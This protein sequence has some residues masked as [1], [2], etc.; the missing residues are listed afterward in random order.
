MVVTMA[1]S[2]QAAWANL[3]PDP[4]S[5]STSTTPPLKASFLKGQSAPASTGS[6]AGESPSDPAPSTP[7]GPAA[8]GTP[9]TDLPLTAADLTAATVADARTL[10]DGEGRRV[11][12]NDLMDATSTT[13][14]NPDGSLTTHSF[15]APVRVRQG[16]RW[17]PVD[18]TILPWKGR[19]QPAATTGDVTFSAGGDTALVRQSLLAGGVYGFD[20]PSA[21]PAPQTQ[22]STVTY[23]NVIDHGDLVLRALP[24][25]YEISLVLRARPAGPLELSLPVVL[26][27]GDRLVAAAGGSRVL[28]ASGTV[29]AVVGQTLMTGA[30]LE[31]GSE[32]PTASSVV[33]TSLTGDAD[34]GQTLVLRPDPAFV[35]DP[36]V[37][38]PITIDPT[39]NLADSKDTYVSNAYTG[40]SYYTST[41]LHVGYYNTPAPAAVGRS[42]V[43]FNMGAVHGNKVLTANLELYDQ[44]QWACNQPM[45]VQSGLDFNS[46]TTWANQPG[47]D[48]AT[49][50]ATPT[51]NAGDTCGGAKYVAI[52]IP[53]LAQ[54]WADA[55]STTGIARLT[56]P[57]EAYNYQY[58][59]FSSANAGSAQAPYVATT[60]ATPPASPS[61]VT[62]TAGNAQATVTWV[63][64][65]NNGGSAIT[66][67]Y[68]NL[69]NS[70]G[71][72]L[73]QHTVTTTSYTATGLTNGSSYYFKIYAINA[74][75]YGGGT[76]SNTVTPAGPPGAPSPVT[77]GAN[78]TATS[79]TWGA[80]PAN[81]SA[82]TGYTVTRFLA[83]TNTLLATTS[84]P[85]A[86]RSQ[87]DTCAVG[88]TYYYRIYASNAKGNSS[89]VQSSTVT[90]GPNGDPQN[91]RAGGGDKT[92]QVFWTNPS[93]DGP[94]LGPAVTS[95]T[96]KLYLHNG[97]TSTQ[98]GTAATVS[99][100]TR[101]GT[102][103]S[104]NGYTI[105]NGSIYY[106]TVTAVSA[107]GSSN[108]VPSNDVTAG[109]PLP[110][111]SV[112]ATAADRSASVTWAPPT[113]NCPQGPCA[114]TYNVSL[115]NQD[116]STTVRTDAV[117][118][119]Q[120]TDTFT[121][122]TNGTRYY[123]SISNTTDYN[124]TSPAASS[125]TV[126]PGLPTAPTSL[127]ATGGANTASV[128]WAA[129]GNDGPPNGPPV[130]AYDI[131]LYDSAGNLL[132][133]S[134][135]Q[136]SAARSYAFS[137]PPSNGL[138]VYFTVHAE[139]ANG[140]GPDGTSNTVHV[141]DAPD[142]PPGPITA[143]E[144]A[145]P[146]YGS[147]SATV[148]W[149]LPDDNGSAIDQFLIQAVDP[150]T[151]NP[152]GQ[153]KTVSCG[154][155]CA[156]PVS[157]TVTGLVYGSSYAFRVA[158]HNS[159]NP[160]HNADLAGTGWSSW[161]PTSGTV[162]IGRPSTLT[163]TLSAI[164]SNPDQS[165]YERGQ[166]AIFTIAV[167][168]PN[169]SKV[170]TAN[171][172]DPFNGTFDVGSTSPVIETTSTLS[173]GTT[174]GCAGCTVTAGS[175]LI[176]GQSLQPGET[177]TF[178]VAGV[179]TGIPS[180]GASDSARL[181]QTLLNI[182]SVADDY[183]GNY[184][185]QTGTVTPAAITASAPQATICNA[186][187]GDEP[188]WTYAS[189]TVGVASSAAVNVANGN[190][191][192]Q[193]TDSTPIQAHGRL[194][195]VLRRTYNS[196]DNVLETLP[197][198][199]GK[200]WLLDLGQTDD[201]AGDGVTATAL[202]VPTTQSLVNTVANPLAVTL[203]DRDGTRHVF[204]PKLLSAAA[205]ATGL[206]PATSTLGA[207][208]L[209]LPA[210]I[211]GQ[212]PYTNLCVD[213][214]Y[215][216]P[217]GVHLAMWRYIAIRSTSP[218]SSPC[219]AANRDNSTT[220]IAVGYVTE[221]P[222]R[223]RAEFKVPLNATT[224]APS[225]P[226]GQLTDLTDASGNTLHYTWNTLAQLTRVDESTCTAAPC[227]SM[228]VKYYD[229]GGADVTGGAGSLTAIASSKV[230]D[231]AGRVTTYTFAS[232]SGTLSGTSFASA[233][234]H[235]ARLLTKVTNPD[236]T[237]VA[238]AYQGAGA[239]CGAADGQLCQITDER[240]KTT[241]FGYDKAA[242]SHP[243]LAPPRVTSITDRR[244]YATTLGYS[245]A[246]STNG[247]QVTVTESAQNH[248]SDRASSDRQQ[249]YGPID[250]QG[251]V[252]QV[253]EGAAGVTTGTAARIT[254]WTW[255]GTDLPGRTATHCRSSSASVRDNNLCSLTRL[256]SG[257]ATDAPDAV[258]T[259][260][261]DDAGML[262]RQAINTSPTNQLIT[263]YGYTRQYALSDGTITTSAESVG[264]GGT[265][266]APTTPSNVVYTLADRV[267]LV[268]PRGNATGASH[269]SYQVSYVVDNVT[270]AS[271]NTS[272]SAGPCQQGGAPGTPVGN[273]GLT[274]SVTQPYASGNAVAYD[275]YDTYGQTAVT[276]NA[277]G[278]RTTYRY[279]SDGS[280]DLSG[281]APAGG[282]LKSVTDAQG[283]FVVNGY[284]AA[285]HRVRSWDRDAT[286]GTTLSSYPGTVSSP[287]VSGFTEQLFG[288]S[289]NTNA[290]SA[291]SSPWRWPTKTTDALGYTSTTQTDARG[292]ITRA[293]DA[294]GNAA[295]TT[296]DE[297]GN[298]TTS[299]TAANAALG[300]PAPTQ[301]SY[302]AFGDQITLTDP[303]QAQRNSTAGAAV[304]K[305]VTARLYYDTVGRLVETDRV[306]M[307]NPTGTTPPACAT[308]GN[309]DPELPGGAL[310]CKT[311]ASYDSEDNQT[312]GTDPDG[313]VSTFR[314]DANARRTDMFTPSTG[315]GA[316]AS[317]TRVV[318]DE[319]GNTV[320]I[321]NPRQFTDGD[322]TCTGISNP[323]VTKATFDAA[324]RARSSTSYR[325]VGSP[326][327]TQF[328]TDADGNQ[329]QVTDANSHTTSVTFDNL[330][331]VS[332]VTAPGHA[333]A[334]SPGT[335][336]TYHLHSAS[337]DPVATIT[338]GTPTDNTNTST[339]VDAQSFDA[340]HRRIDS[341]HALQVS[342]N[343]SYSLDDPR[344]L[345]AVTSA[346]ATS[347]ATG[348]TNT[349]SRTSY[350]P[351]GNVV[352]AYSP[353]AFTGS[354]PSAT[355][356]TYSQVPGAFSSD[357]MT[358][359]D[360]DADNRPVTAYTPRTSGSVTDPNGNSLTGP[361]AQQC[362]STGPSTANLPSYPGTRVCVRTVNYDADS[363]RSS[364]TL[365][366]A[367]SG[368]PNRR[369]DYTYTT[370]NLVAAVST[371]DPSAGAATGARVTSAAIGYDGSGRPLTGTDVLG[372]VSRTV[373]NP[374]GSVAESDQPTGS[375]GL[376]HAMKYVYNAAGQ[377]T[378]ATLL[379]T[380]SGTAVTAGSAT[381][382]DTTTTVYYA[383]GLT[384]QVS[385][386]AVGAS[387]SDVTQYSYDPVGN[388]SATS[389]PSANAATR[390]ANNTNGTTTTYTYYPD[391][392]IAT[393]LAP[394]SADGTKLRRTSYNYDDAGRKTNVGV[395]L[396][397]PAPTNSVVTAGSAQS[398]TYQP[399]GWM[400]QQTGRTD[401]TAASNASVYD[402]DGN[403]T[404]F[405][406]TFNPASPD[407]SA[408]PGATSGIVG[409]Q[410]P[411]DSA[412]Y[413]L[414]GG[415]RS[416]SQNPG[417]GVVRSS[418]FSI[419]A[420]GSLT[421]RIDRTAAGDKTT[422]YAYGDAGQP[423]M[424]TSGLEDGAVT[425]W[426][427]DK[428]GN[429][430]RQNSGN[431]TVTTWQ[432]DN[433]SSSGDNS[434]TRIGL[435]S[436][437]N[438]ANA[439]TFD[440][441]DI[442]YSYDEVGRVLTEQHSGKGA[443]GAALAN[444]T[445]SYRYQQD[446]RLSSF[447]NG[448]AAA[449]NVT[450]DHDGNR[451]TYG[452]ATYTYNAD[453]S[454]ATSRANATLTTATHNYSY[455][456]YGR[457]TGDSCTTNS[458]DGL[459]RLT[460]TAYGTSL[461]ATCSQGVATTTSS[462][463]YR[464]DPMDRQTERTSTAKNALGKVTAT[465]TDNN[466]Y[467]GGGQTVVGELAGNGVGGT[468]VNR[469]YQLDASGTVSAL[470]STALE[471][472]TLDGQ[473]SVVA[474]TSSSGG[475]SSVLCALR[476]DPYGQNVDDN[477]ATTRTAS[478]PCTS[479]S[480]K[481]D[482]LYHADRQDAATGNYQLGSRTYNP[483]TGS[484]LTRD[485]AR[486]GT[487]AQE[488]GLGA[489]PL[490]ENS[491]AY[492]NGDP[493]NFD[494]PS[495][496][497]TAPDGG[498]SWTAQQLATWSEHFQRMLAIRDQIAA[499]KKKADCGFIGC[500]LLGDVG[501]GIK[502]GSE[503][504]VNFSAGVADDVT[505][506]LTAGHNG[507]VEIGQTF[508]GPG[509]DA[510][511]N[512]GRGTSE[513]V[514]LV[515]G[516]GAAFKAAKALIKLP[517]LVKSAGGASKFVTGLIKDAGTAAKARGIA[518]VAKA[519]TAANVAKVKTANVVGGV[520]DAAA[521][522]KAGIVQVASNLGRAGK[523][524]EAGAGGAAKAEQYVYR[525]HGGDSG[526][527]GHS[528]TPANPM[529]M[530]NP[531]AE[532][533]LPKGN[534]GQM[535][536][537][538]RVTDMEGVMQRDA[539]PLDG[540]PGGAP[541]WLFPDPLSQLEVHWTIP[542]VPPW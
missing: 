515:S 486:S 202:E 123:V 46:A 343:L 388:L 21:L 445:F 90:C 279:Y 424:M 125:N 37:V 433:A 251:R 211:S 294:R 263:T 333:S 393:T 371:P 105:T 542:L 164:G 274:C 8:T 268:P 254:Q 51:L 315:A 229:A 527:M 216:P 330:D 38:L 143:S 250:S 156:S 179:F 71:T 342:F 366:T 538:A 361:E 56:A 324:D 248:P 218:G 386:P 129:P 113:N 103:G 378:A 166:S 160:S 286:A 491:Y 329:T 59:E 345:T 172:T 348:G 384:N 308:A 53:T 500:S 524:A 249:V 48:G 224:L 140:T 368:T 331:R 415:L 175:L 302:D 522:F 238:Y 75:G 20:W 253:I 17:A 235:G 326:Q 192:V 322:G 261:Y 446:G 521:A 10:A 311:L 430:T 288:T 397:G 531:R 170:L 467:D 186:D 489:D 60:Y 171:I 525:V 266:G 43:A 502:V 344:Q 226:V 231:A 142:A 141:A 12:V 506:T 362:T 195:F 382:A 341:V 466:Y 257:G 97:G 34:L 161:S 68:V 396:V 334:S 39:V 456:T 169:S 162:A 262:Q 373:Y 121:G 458:Y 242:S 389:P 301:Y 115:I 376:T 512:I 380:P 477:A 463:A 213:T 154:T 347:T 106:A 462:T 122:L 392:A 252:A 145:G 340:D 91:V 64:P 206:T 72:F 284:D 54:H 533:G 65:A 436:N 36:A 317:H 383:D 427:F 139:S 495:G 402:A 30:A 374:D 278:N 354:I 104:F 78:S 167:T 110:P 269:A 409:S 404:C 207:R 494:D 351:N 395:D 258:T 328:V 136:P 281:T 541:E 22:G 63:A 2:A 197:G 93:N 418:T 478:S 523:A 108:P 429:P 15:S 481:S 178:K 298:L 208:S 381:E 472:L 148:M 94:P 100:T 310:Y 77:A 457:L 513:A 163:K 484:F 300:T 1:V 367:T 165:V 133:T 58:K 84:H 452:P 514:Q 190:L 237:T 118:A 41:D 201:L 176:A 375:G 391:N 314:Y 203:I 303:V 114:A 449:Q 13:F 403:V 270:S 432:Y 25:G 199:F 67:Y 49:V 255:D 421:A 259:Y 296:F 352:A 135:P 245:T 511:Y 244:G 85:A 490:T 526:P 363:N 217:A 464:Y 181:C 131:S 468:D 411:A 265:V 200:G 40:T 509:L 9:A 504:F 325:S 62:A 47:A 414:D 227:R 18:T 14:A 400:I 223:L 198:S 138:D 26:P 312:S 232:T 209:T 349:R 410:V 482:V 82:V 102:F 460:G 306:R 44:H 293:V 52:S 479:G 441:A 443:A 99:S 42:F 469:D 212:Q 454:I 134:S 157:G 81:G 24:V 228:S 422:T 177:R 357:Y 534:S 360:Y 530:S 96:L 474:S 291:I 124:G 439:G 459:D 70:S 127:I 45:N 307:L 518:T 470:S 426:N 434:L 183:S 155:G 398:F 390:D 19:L 182:A 272:P 488:Q 455:D 379:R 159:A 241:A 493:V 299:L 239:S 69:Y 423:L 289:N 372:L 98:V 35:A 339:I 220:P 365:P 273:T 119:S 438:A 385:T 153:S 447:T 406:P 3:P 79:L 465:A 437:S 498:R 147:S 233:F 451:L 128:T 89:T 370:D 27:A 193:S 240:G 92:V 191:V 86:D 321:C 309:S 290:A 475:S 471:Y 23:R 505:S 319:D 318:F 246:N 4:G 196:Q 130:T 7:A 496:H 529:G 219:S 450:W 168:N 501:D 221:R 112:V 285:G 276:I 83:S 234:P 280:T 359:I 448:S 180:S 516:A 536:T 355:S 485:G 537:R 109:P 29:L 173:P 305:S 230:T 480:S 416:V 332:A 88:T 116:T 387:G 497:M 528:W 117:D 412:S 31:P 174:T 401:T 492:V 323:Y 292:E 277:R 158:A 413:Y 152:T 287:A 535:L 57:N 476:Y 214:V 267:A 76:Q 408:C 346:M 425:S 417:N 32:L 435:S 149:S 483:S 275:G 444:T 74:A 243:A 107:N 316:G 151:G 87:S 335:L 394:V 222:D 431:G 327:T 337:G 358:R 336:T 146:H 80:A 150:N 540:N 499:D 5:S 304:G 126:I 338:P 473:G 399:N 419:D 187:L 271:P 189:K 510:S 503:G 95:Y 247:D 11:A 256:G 144:D 508:H 428:D 33:P 377:A 111:Q 283:H 215:A 295:V 101:G 188:W 236:S 532:L 507:A 461:D 282:W 519:K 407:T 120:N 420:A 264:D 405:L 184:N 297:D 73:N 364:L 66:G 132:A 369:V 225:L 205:D 204:T 6:R 16:G 539:L 313:Q 55:S 517:A 50:Y 320:E 440:L 185:V 194:A 487:A 453:D 137:S 260:T 210:S 356:S 353:R 520:K 350:D 28:N 442:R 61:N